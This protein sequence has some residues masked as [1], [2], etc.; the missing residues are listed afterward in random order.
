MVWTERWPRRRLLVGGLLGM[1]VALLSC[2]VAPG[3]WGIALGCTL[4]FLA[5]GVACGIAQAALMDSDPERREQRMAEWAISGW[6]GDL[7]SPL[8]LMVSEQLGLGWRGAFAALTAALCL[9]AVG[10]AH[11]PVPSRVAS[12][13]GEQAAFGLRRTLGLLLKQWRLMWWLFGVALCSLLD[14]IFAVFAGIRVAADSGVS[15]VAATLTAF[16]AGGVVGL[17]LTKPLLDRAS[18]HRVLVGSCLGCI[19]SYG[20]WLLLGTDTLGIGM[21]FA[22][23]LF[24]AFQYPIAQAAAYRALPGRSTL[25]AA[26]ASAFGAVDLGAPLILGWLVDRCGVLAALWAL[27][28]QPVG[29]LAI[30]AVTRFATADGR[31]AT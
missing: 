11:V 28:L 8:L 18:P 10:A 5:S 20:A 6:V 29:L 3:L 13:D 15:A 26:A 2:A 16:T 9:A 12:D 22:S 21:V 14:E 1:A 25:V 23:G 30:A 31:A 7:V 19:V 4:Y 24:V 17:L 27:L